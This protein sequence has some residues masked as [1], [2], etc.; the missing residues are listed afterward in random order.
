[1]PRLVQVRN[2]DL[3]RNYTVINND[4]NDQLLRYQSSKLLN[5]WLRF[6]P[7]DQ[8]FNDVLNETQNADYRGNIEFYDVVFRNDLGKRTRKAFK[9][10][11][12]QS[13]VVIDQSSLMVNDGTFDKPFTVALWIK[14][15]N[16]ATSGVIFGKQQEEPTNNIRQFEIY[17]DLET[18]QATVT[19]YDRNTS[20]NQPGLYFASFSISSILDQQWHFLAMSFDPSSVNNKIQFYL[21]GLQV[22][23]DPQENINYTS[24]RDFDVPYVL[25]AAY[26]FTTIFAAIPPIVTISPYGASPTGVS[27]SEFALWSQ[28]IDQD[29]IYA[30]Y[31]SI[32]SKVRVEES[33]FLSES[34]RLQLREQDHA[35]GSYPG[36]SYHGMPDFNG[37]YN[38]NFDDAK[39]INLVSDYAQASIEFNEA[40]SNEPTN[41]IKLGILS[42][43]SFEITVFDGT[44]EVEKNFRFENVRSKLNA[45]T[46]TLIVVDVTKVTDSAEL[47]R[48]FA[49]SINKASMGVEARSFGSTVRLRLHKPNVGSFQMG[50]FIEAFN[51]GVRAKA[52]KKIDQFTID[53]NGLK[54]PAM[55]PNDSHWSNANAVFPHRFEGIQAP[56]RMLIGVSDQHVKFTPGQN[57]KPFNEHRIPNDDSDPFYALGTEDNVLPNF[58][59]K[60][61]SKNSFVIDVSHASGESQ[62][63]FST[64]SQEHERHSGF[65]YFD[66]V[67]KTWE[68]VNVEQPLE[69]YSS[70]FDE[71]SNSML[72]VIP[73][74][75]WGNFP[76]LETVP[77]S[78]ENVKHI[79]KPNSFAGFPMA[80]KF[81]GSASNVFK[82][83]EHIKGPFLLEKIEF[84]VNGTLA[85]YPPYVSQQNVRIVQNILYRNISATNLLGKNLLIYYRSTSN[86]VPMVEFEVDANDNYVITVSFRSGVTTANQIIN[87]INAYVPNLNNIVELDPI[88]NVDTPQL[89][90]E[91][92]QFLND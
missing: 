4:L 65:S 89:I 55:V 5:A 45:S 34:P 84:E 12:Q 3:K 64:G 53:G 38:V 59:A 37:R 41:Y 78:N 69:F 72:S 30:I 17:L 27:Y 31:R 57:I 54:W 48:S 74:T 2:Y 83:R 75:F 10:S 8:P 51:D 68:P 35:T 76:N 79:G 7:E 92:Y 22:Q 71:A 60:L 43:L 85:S 80:S 73:S 90:E 88:G 13:Y 29:S 33:G 36:N 42:K 66:F 11:D 19:F 6:V 14:L 32:S 52:I 40:K 18:E 20:I 81:D 50:S 46:E 21:D 9:P 70:N 62:V 25:G 47:A 56:G 91:I 26:S 15:N 39:I 1:M 23:G 24:M 49:S 87:A 86:V 63:Y 61:S 67:S 82:L 58:S 44:V 77:L 28:A 16:D